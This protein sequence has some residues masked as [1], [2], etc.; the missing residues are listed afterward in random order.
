MKY[1]IELYINDRPVE[2]SSDPKILMNFKE[3]ELRNP[4][5]VR[6]SFTK[7]IQIQ[8]TNQNNDIF[9]HIWNLDRYQEGL[10][11]NP[12][13]KTGFKLFVNGELYEKGYVKLDKVEMSNN[14]MVYSITLY[15]GLGQFFYNLTYE[16]G[17]NNKK[18]LASLQY[19]DEWSSEPDLNFTANKETVY[20]AWGKICGWGSGDPKWNVINFAPCYNGIPQDFSADKVLINN[21]GLNVFHTYE[22]VDGVT[23]RPI[24]NG[25]QNASGYSVGTLSAPATEWQT[26]DLRS[27]NQRPVL[28]M[29]NLIQACC[30]PENNG[31]YQV[32]LDPHFFHV[33]NPYY[34]D[35]WVTLPMLKDLD[36]VGGGETTVVTGATVTK[37]GTTGYWNVNFDGGGGA[38]NNVN[39]DLSIRFNPSESTSATNLYTARNYSSNTNFTLVGSRYVKTYHRTDGVTIQLLAF[40]AGGQVVGQSKA[41]LLATEKN[42]IYTGEPLYKDFWKQGDPGVEP[43][44]EFLQGYFKKISGNY[45][46]CD[47]A[48][49][50]KGIKFSLNNTTEFASLRLKVRMSDAYRTKFAFSGSEAMSAPSQSFMA[51]YDAQYYNTSGNH[52]VGEVYPL[53]RA[54]GEVGFVVDSMEAV[55]TDYAGLFS[56]TEITKEKLLS[57]DKSPCDYLLSYCKMFGLYFYHDS[58]EASDDEQK[59]PAG[60]VHIMDRHTFYTDEVVD[61]SKLIDYSRKVTITP[62]T[63]SAKWYSFSQEQVE[64]DVNN[65]YKEL[66]GNDYGKQLVNTNYNFD[67]NTTE[68]YDG[69][70]FKA[71]VMARKKDKY[72]KTPIGTGI[73][74]YVYNGLEY[75][76]F[77]AD[78]NGYQTT[79]L[80]MP[81][82]TTNDWTNINIYGLPYYDNFPK[83]VCHTEENAAS[84]GSGVLLFLNGSLTTQGESGLI[85]YW[86]TDDVMDMVY[87]NDAQPCWILTANESDAAGNRIAYRLNY[88]PNFTR[89]KVLFGQE[90]FIAHSWNFGHPQV[91]FV[92]NMYT[93]EGD[94][95]YDKCWKDYIGDMYNENTRKL[96]C[97]VRAEF[98]GKP[99]PYWLRRF[100]WFENSLWRLNEIKD[101]NMSSFEVTQMEFI[102]VQSQSNYD[103]DYINE[104][105]SFEIRLDKYE[106]PCTGGTVTGMVTIQSGGGWFSGDYFA[107]YEMPSETVHYYESTQI[108]SPGSARGYQTNFTLTIPANNYD[109]PLRW[110]I[111]LEDDFDQGYS[112]YIN[113]ATCTPASSLALNPTSRVVRPDATGTTFTISS[114]NV[115]N[116]TAS[117]TSGQSNVSNYHID[118]NILTVEFV[119]GT[120]ETDRNVQVTVSGTGEDGPL[121]ATGTV[122]IVGTLMN[123][124]PTE[125]VL[126]YDNLLSGASLRG[127]ATLYNEYQEGETWSAE[128]N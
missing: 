45:V 66:F 124:V 60:V 107:A 28:R 99:W 35:S 112:V 73:P 41:Y 39:L 120:S 9:Q 64:S 111:R 74:N 53:G 57:G 72:F 38:I 33:N 34:F 37:Q 20:D 58:A 90:G 88:L 69:N 116:I 82:R 10:E 54:M 83:L 121:S 18:N 119:S 46:F 108:I 100:Y 77:A 48:G 16:E 75:S 25:M 81:V 110:Q 55:V 15:G 29:Y 70:A 30:Q 26:Y 17:N 113:Q 8:G 103:V 40:N 19:T 102:K 4:T 87:L 14:T 52:T 115:T 89:D 123:V 5:I 2:F 62:A 84:D 12:I 126:D 104:Q 1:D 95:I 93:T 78:G 51:L 125:I 11:F 86:L 6:N 79:E 21:R 65:Q 98:D 27:Y 61:L 92:P 50:K 22:V 122:R 96:N 118:G 56:G 13:Q 117:I 31:G 71:G 97:Y 7:Q 76:L 94:S 3:T 114:Q 109:Y 85:N 42:N 80:E 128:M 36:G 32:K 43:E 101:L 63:A 106:L 68:L 127:T 49:N 44:Y 105:G 59:Y 23:Y 67:S 47:M 91:T 24:L